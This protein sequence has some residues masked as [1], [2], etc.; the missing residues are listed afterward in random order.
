MDAM[1]GGGTLHVRTFAA[2]AAHPEREGQRERCVGVVF[3]DTGAGIPAEDRPHVFD[4]FFTTKD[5]GR[6]TGL[7]LSVSYGIVHDH[8]G[9]FDLDSEPGRGTRIIIYLPVDVGADSRPAGGGTA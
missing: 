3:E 6:G 7:G 9:W 2:D 8:G 4:P 5:V 1:E